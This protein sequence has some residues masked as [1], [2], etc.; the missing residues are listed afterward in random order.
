VPRV[1][2]KVG[3]RVDAFY[4]LLGNV[5][6]DVR[7]HRVDVA[8]RPYLLDPNAVCAGTPTNQVIG[9]QSKDELRELVLASVGLPE[10]M[11]ILEGVV[12]GD[13]TVELLGV[14]ID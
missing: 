7:E 10:D 1:L 5:R 6:E 14:E 12:K 11:K 13:A 9:E 8:E 4:L 3:Q 2:P